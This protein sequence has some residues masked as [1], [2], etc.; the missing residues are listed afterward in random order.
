MDATAL[1]DTQSCNTLPTHYTAQAQ[2]RRDLP[3]AVVGQSGITKDTVEKTTHYA[4]EGVDYYLL[5]GPARGG[6]LIDVWLRTN[7][8]GLAEPVPRLRPSVLHA[9]SDF[10]NALIVHAVGTAL[11]IPT[12]Y[13]TRCFGEDY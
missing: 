2:A 5:P 10:H 8:E 13:E 12:V 9:H 3:V 4:H 11:G 1:P 7:I 6:A